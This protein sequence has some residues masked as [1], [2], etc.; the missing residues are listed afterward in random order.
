MKVKLYDR[1]YYGPPTLGIIQVS[2]SYQNLYLESKS[3]PE[4]TGK[5]SS[6]PD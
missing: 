4:E 5:E 1:A 2:D 6:I 3:L